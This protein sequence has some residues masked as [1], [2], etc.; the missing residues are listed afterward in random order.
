MEL[1]SSTYYSKK[2]DFRE[3]SHSD[4]IA[5]RLLSMDGVKSVTD[6]GFI[7]FDPREIDPRI[8]SLALNG[9]VAKGER[10]MEK[11]HEWGNVPFTYHYIQGDYIF[12][13]LPLS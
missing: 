3:N 13:C 10:V 8:V 11:F 2:I 6:Y 7:E 12:P 1:V 5:A 4:I 9:K